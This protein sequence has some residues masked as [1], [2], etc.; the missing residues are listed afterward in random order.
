MCSV[1]SEAQLTVDDTERILCHV[2]VRAIRVMHVNN[3]AQSIDVISNQL[4]TDCRNLPNEEL[5]GQVSDTFG[6]ILVSHPI[7]SF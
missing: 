2:I 6:E 7:E 4:Q 5:I 1:G 3:Q